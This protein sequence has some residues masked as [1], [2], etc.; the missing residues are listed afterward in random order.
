MSGL[1]FMRE[2]N[3][4]MLHKLHPNILPTFYNSLNIDQKTFRP[5]HTYTT[6][7]ADSWFMPSQWETSLESNTVSHWP[8]ANIEPALNHDT[9]YAAYLWVSVHWS[10]KTTLLFTQ[11]PGH[12]CDKNVTQ[13]WSS[14]QIRTI[15]PCAC[16]GNAGMRSRHA[17]R[18]VRHARAV[19]HVGIAN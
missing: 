9:V 7:S 3:I 12:M 17:S 2:R 10:D 4:I 13:P 16:A 1:N 8:G 18:H 5:D 19:M 15:A 14:C 11:S 6:T